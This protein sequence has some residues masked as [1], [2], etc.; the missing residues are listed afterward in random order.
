MPLQCAAARHLQDL[1]ARPHGLRVFT[2]DQQHLV[3][4]RGVHEVRIDLD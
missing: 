1:Q 2:R 4:L 3:D